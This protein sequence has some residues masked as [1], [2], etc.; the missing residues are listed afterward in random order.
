MSF[1]FIFGFNQWLSYTTGSSDDFFF[2]INYLVL[3]KRKLD[4]LINFL[5]QDIE[6]FK[7]DYEQRQTGT[8]KIERYDLVL[9]HLGTFQ[10]CITKTDYSTAGKPFFSHS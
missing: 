8:K 3:V 9:P 7:K 6:N 10:I 4:F 1:L 2:L 5:I